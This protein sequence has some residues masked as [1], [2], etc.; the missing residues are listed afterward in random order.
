V[1]SKSSH[2]T[3]ASP[4][5]HGATQRPDASSRWSPSTATT[6]VILGRQAFLA[7][8]HRETVPAERPPLLE[9]L[10]ALLGWSLARP[11]LL[12]F[13]ANAAHPDVLSFTR[14]GSGVVFWNTHARRGELPEL[15]L[16][17]RA[18]R[19]LGEDDRSTVVR[20]LNAHSRKALDEEAPLRI[21]FGA[22][23]NLGAR[24]A[25]LALMDQLLV[26]T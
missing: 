8:L 6:P 17:P 7:A 1:T 12:R 4:R 13:T 5:D 14:A 15:E 11:T 22:L 19:L 25:V 2:R 23:K 3:T 20:T 9:V 18:A 21:G 16:L 24:T 10:D 26:V